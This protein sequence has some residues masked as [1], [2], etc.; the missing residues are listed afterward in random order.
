MIT[1][2]LNDYGFIGTELLRNAIRPHTATGKTEASIKFEVKANAKGE[3]LVL[4]TR[5]FFSTL[6][7]GRG[8]RKSFQKSKFLDNMLEW[9]TARGI[10]N[11]MDQ[12]KKLQLAKFL[13]YKINKDGDQTFQHGGHDVYSK[14]LA[15]FTKEL[16]SAVKKDFI[17]SYR[18]NL[19]L[20]NIHGA[21][22]KKA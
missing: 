3:T 19:K 20:T 9:M 1:K 18:A 22:S 11:D 6:E 4:K 15:K 12:K 8:P 5:K 14:Q 16:K 2:V 21:G 13:V 10:G 7:T 17:L